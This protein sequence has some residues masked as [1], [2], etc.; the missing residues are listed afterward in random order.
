MSPKSSK[1]EELTL[2]QVIK[3]SS[4]YTE[5]AGKE[6]DIIGVD[7]QIDIDKA[8]PVTKAKKYHMVGN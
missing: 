4:D 5:E 3:A 8:K 6:F 1:P 2:A 7:W